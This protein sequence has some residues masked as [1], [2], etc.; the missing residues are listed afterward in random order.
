MVRLILQTLAT[1]RSCPL[2]ADI[3]DNARSS[4]RGLEGHV[5]A[6]QS[7]ARGFRGP[8]ISARSLERFEI[9][10]AIGWAF[11]RIKI[12]KII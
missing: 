7:D 4:A 1:A 8:E 6:L 5:H 12:V 10:S 2:N 11:F 3:N 9:A